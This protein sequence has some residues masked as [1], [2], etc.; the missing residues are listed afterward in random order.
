MERER[1]KK[2]PRSSVVSRTKK[3]VV[4]N[5]GFDSQIPSVDE[6]LDDIDEALTT[7]GFAAKMAEQDAIVRENQE[8]RESMTNDRESLEIF[9]WTHPALSD[10]ILKAIKPQRQKRK[11]TEGQ[12]GCF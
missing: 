6:T 7:T 9:E 4:K 12:C 8:V 11:S 10:A 2:K 3:T 1:R 5:S